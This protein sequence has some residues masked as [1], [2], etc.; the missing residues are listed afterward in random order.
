MF[1]LRTALGMI[2]TGRA[3]GIDRVSNEMIKNL[4]RNNLG[5]IHK[6]INLSFTN[7]YVPTA[8]KRAKLH[9]L[10]KSDKDPKF[11]ESYR[12]ISL[13]ECLGKLMER[14]EDVGERSQLLPHSLARFR[15]WRSTEDPLLDLISNLQDTRAR[16]GNNDL[17]V[18]LLDFEEAFDR[19]DPW[20]LLKIMRD[21]GVPVYLL[22]WYH[23]FLMDRRYCVC[24]GTS[25][26]KV[27]RFALGVPQGSFSGP[28]LF[29]LYPSTLT[30]ETRAAVNREVRTVE[31]ADDV[32][33]WVRLNRTE[34]G[35]YDISQAQTAL[36][37]ILDWSE[38]Y[39][40][41]VSISESID[42]TKTDNRIPFPG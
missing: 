41:N 42:E 20:I 33:L 30:T 29:A 3:A 28:L 21:V 2:H 14:L 4:N 40:I 9:P 5:R 7:G 15:R 38:R 37:A 17:L 23:S 11:L 31:F 25:Y 32:N 12:P 22:R 35:S 16:T 27:V 1:E 26:S 10:L 24:V 6:L 36:N 19:V 34:D 8:W 18:I 39:G 13:L